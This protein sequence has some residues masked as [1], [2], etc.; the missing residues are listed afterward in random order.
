[1]S[2]RRKVWVMFDGGVP[3]WVEA[4]AKRA[5]A[6]RLAREVPF[7][8]HRRGDVVLSRKQRADMAARLESWLRDMKMENDDEHDHIRHGCGEVG[9]VKPIKD[10]I[11]LLRGGR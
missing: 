1:M 2:K 5:K 6:I 9:C 4:S 10:A 3:T 8:E 11:R 7:V